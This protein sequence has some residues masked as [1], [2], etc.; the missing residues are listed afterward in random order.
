MEGE[1]YWFDKK[2]H[3]QHGW[4]RAPEGKMYFDQ[5]GIAKKGWMQQDSQWY[6]FDGEG[7]MNCSEW[8]MDGG[9]YYYFR[10]DGV[11]AAGTFVKSEDGSTYYVDQSGA[12]KAGWCRLNGSWYCF[13]NQGRMLK[14]TYKDG[15]YIDDDGI[16]TKK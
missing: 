11:M 13:D 15:G 16:W 12:R 14:N 8:L 5:A 1:K 6:H 9:K 4:G 7:L 3:L 2:G 10:S